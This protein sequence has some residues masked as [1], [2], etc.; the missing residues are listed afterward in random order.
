MGF[1]G[2]HWLCGGLGLAGVVDVFDGAWTS[3]I[4]VAL[5]ARRGE[6]VARPLRSLGHGTYRG[7]RAG[8]ECDVDA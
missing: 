8:S 4:G 1:V 7:G 2:L 6:S 3:G 5:G